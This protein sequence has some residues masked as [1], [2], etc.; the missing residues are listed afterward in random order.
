MRKIGSF[1]WLT[2]IAGLA[3][4]FC[5]PYT[6][7]IAATLLTP[8]LPMFIGMGFAKQLPRAAADALHSDSTDL[9]HEIKKITAPL[10]ETTSRLVIPACVSIFFL[11]CSLVT[12]GLTTSFAGFSGDTPKTIFPWTV[13]KGVE[14]PAAV[15]ALGIGMVVLMLATAVLY[16]MWF[17]ARRR[18]A[19]REANR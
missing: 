12:F 3:L 15:L 4:A 10:A 13:W 7:V 18:D 5:N 14:S 9:L 17:C 1:W 16:I 6:G 2:Y 19:E 11:A 8:L